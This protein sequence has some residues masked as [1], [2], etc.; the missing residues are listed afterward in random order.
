M[1]P[2][3]QC[4][5]VALKRRK[6]ETWLE[7]AI[8]NGGL[9]SGP[10]AVTWALRWG[11]ARER[12]GTEPTVDQVADLWRSSRRNA[13]RDQTHWRKAFPN[14]DTPA[15]VFDDPAARRKAKELAKLMDDFDANLRKGSIRIDRAVL[16]VGM[17]P[18]N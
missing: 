1:A 17:L 15:V 8:A 4:S 5:A 13:F 9:R 2:P 10:K 18:A 12:L 16:D 14:H 11:V 7:V 6:P 3:L